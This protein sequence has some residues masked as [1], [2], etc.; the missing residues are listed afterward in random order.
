M[1]IG[2]ELKT[3][4]DLPLIELRG[5]ITDADIEDLVNTMEPLLEGPHATVVIDI[6]AI[7]FIGSFGLGKIVSY[8]ARMRK[9]GR[10]LVLVNTNPDPETFVASML[11]LTNLYK[12]LKIV[13]DPTAV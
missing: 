5:N 6:S 10:E 4:R 7:T 12:V 2:T 9:A 11:K 1:T 3:I 13:T 8:N